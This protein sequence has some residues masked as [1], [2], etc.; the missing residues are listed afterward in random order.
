MKLL[1]SVSDPSQPS[2]HVAGPPTWM[3]ASTL[4]I[5][6]EAAAYLKKIASASDG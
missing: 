2:A 5:A 4:L 1:P 3:S 6:A